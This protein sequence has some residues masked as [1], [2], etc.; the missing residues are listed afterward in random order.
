VPLKVWTIVKTSRVGL[1]PVGKVPMRSGL[2][3]MTEIC[4]AAPWRW[5]MP[6]LSLYH[7][8]AVD[9]NPAL[10]DQFVVFKGMAL[11]VD[12]AAGTEAAG[13]MNATIMRP[14]RAASS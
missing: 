9:P 7:P 5:T 14:R 4:F 10:P 3:P 13:A 11:M 6:D 12:A 2:V 1:A 8:G